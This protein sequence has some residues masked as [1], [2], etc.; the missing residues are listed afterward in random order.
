MNF[1][2][3]SYMCSRKTTGNFPQNGTQNCQIDNQVKCPPVARKTILLLSVICYMPPLILL[4]E[5][6]VLILCVILMIISKPKYLNIL[7]CH[8]YS[9]PLLNDK[10]KF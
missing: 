2:L 1:Q 5:G 4:V 8:I 7:L 10:E 6:F 3:L 9:H